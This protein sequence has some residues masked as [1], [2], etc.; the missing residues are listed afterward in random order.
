MERAWSS[1]VA[2]WENNST[3]K[4]II[5]SATPSWREN[6]VNKID[7]SIHTLRE[8]HRQTERANMHQGS[9]TEGES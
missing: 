3:H 4:P 5:D 1:L 7:H 6:M 8:R 9:F 2:K